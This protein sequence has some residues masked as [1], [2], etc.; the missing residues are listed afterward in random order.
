MASN[1]VAINTS[2]KLYKTFR[3]LQDTQTAIT[4]LKVRM[5]SV[6]GSPADYN[7]LGTDYG[8]SSTAASTLYGTIQSMNSTLIAS[9]FTF[10]K[11]YD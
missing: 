5:D 8:I 1:Y 9:P 6:L 11:D 3:K 7:A 4:Q 2:T 10:I